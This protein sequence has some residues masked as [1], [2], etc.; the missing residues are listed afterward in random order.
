MTTVYIVRHAEA[1]GN[2]YCRAQGQY[3]SNLTKFGQSQLPYLVER[4]RDIDVDVIY[5]SSLKRAYLTV[6][7]IG[8]DKGLDVIKSDNLRELGMG[9]LEDIPWAELP[10]ID[11]DM[12]YKW[13]YEP[14]KCVFEGGEG[15]KQSADRF[16]D[17]FLNIVEENQGKNIVI[18]SHGAVIRYFLYKIKGID[19]SQTKALEWCENTGI[20]KV[21]VHNDG[22]IEVEYMFD[23]SHLEGIKSP[24]SIPKDWKLTDEQREIGFHLWFRNVDL[25]TEFDILCDYMRDFYINAYQSDEKFNS[26]EFLIECKKSQEKFDKSVQFAILHDQIVGV[27]R[28]DVLISTDNI[29]Y[30]GN[31]AITPNYRGGNFAPQIIGNFVCHYRNLG[32]DTLRARVSKNNPRAIKFYEKLGF[33]NS[34]EMSNKNGEHYL[35]DLD[36]RV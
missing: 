21:I 26:E 36:L 24:F 23:V 3:N 1:E 14:H 25:D 20:T 13:N 11:K 10:H 34:G 17:E 9:N 22:S 18:G 12:F 8:D 4:F 31:I 16:Y 30:I 28:I 32:K 29:G 35:M 5:A 19:L 7:A 33:V 27:S 2:V 15:P 6:K